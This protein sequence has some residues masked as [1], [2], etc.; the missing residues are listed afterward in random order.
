MA[1]Q[2]EGKEDEDAGPFF[3][4]DEE[5]TK[6]IMVDE[7]LQA[8]D[9]PT[10]AHSPKPDP[11]LPSEPWRE[12]LPEIV[13][14]ENEPPGLLPPADDDT[15]SPIIEIISGSNDPV[16]EIHPE[17]P[18]RTE[19]LPSHMKRFPLKPPPDLK[20]PRKGRP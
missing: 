1:A 17:L 5:P 13:A 14:A 10:A 20:D 18:R 4:D 11:P 12:P 7:L 16:L 2:K 19:F 3:D 8:H 9:L 15:S 6:L